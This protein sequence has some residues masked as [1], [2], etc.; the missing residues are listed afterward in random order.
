MK[1][2]LTILFFILKTI[3]VAQTYSQIKIGNQVWMQTNLNTDRFSNG[4]FIQQAR[5]LEEFGNSTSPCWMFYDNNSKLQDVT[6]KLYNYYAVIDKRNVCPSGW[7][8]P[9]INEWDELKSFVG[10]NGGSL[11]ASGSIRAST[12][13]WFKDEWIVLRSGKINYPID[14]TNKGKSSKENI[15]WWEPNTNATNSSGF[16]A[17]PTG[18]IRPVPFSGPE[19]IGFN[20]FA[21]FWASN[22]NTYNSSTQ[23]ASS[24]ILNYN[25]DYLRTSNEYFYS[26]LSIR[27]MLNENL[28][29]KKNDAKIIDDHALQEISTSNSMYNSNV[30]NPLGTLEI[31][32]TLNVDDYSDLFGFDIYLDDTKIDKTL[33]YAS[34]NENGAVS[35][36][37]PI[38]Y[39][40]IY[41]SEKHA[42]YFTKVRR[43]SS[44]RNVLINNNVTTSI[45]L[46]YKNIKLQ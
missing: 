33:Y 4:E 42:N 35:I 7:H 14:E 22:R 18:R 1:F 24:V 36:L 25:D 43:T 30:K 37:V 32:N 19:F 27:C 26:G 20:M 39:H 34:K 10:G 8:V 28:D 38:G 46:T 11:K 41:L 17:Q 15:L 23:L 45:K 44:F 16:T 31:I 13:F 9:T 3:I 5:S 6:G 29:S 12:G 2:I 40:N 21:Q